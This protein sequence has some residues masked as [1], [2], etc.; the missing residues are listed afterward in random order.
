MILKI[1]LIFSVIYILV[2]IS[3]FLSITVFL[4]EC[5]HY[6]E[7]IFMGRSSCC[8]PC[9]ILPTFCL[10][11]VPAISAIFAALLSKAKWFLFTPIFMSVFVFS[12]FLLSGPI[13]CIRYGGSTKTLDIGYVFYYFLLSLPTFIGGIFGIVMGNLIYAIY[14]KFK[15]YHR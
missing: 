10:I 3:I 15:E 5:L 13:Y 9:W 2:I 12:L 14:C 7:L 4:D 6:W 11:V 8:C 1:N